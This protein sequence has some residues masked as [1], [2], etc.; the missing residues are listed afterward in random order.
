MLTQRACLIFAP[1]L[2]RMFEIEFRRGK[3]SDLDHNRIERKFCRD[4][5]I[6]E[7]RNFSSSVFHIS[8]K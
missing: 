3:L 2:K 8:D 4:D 5:E 7:L 1:F 6:E